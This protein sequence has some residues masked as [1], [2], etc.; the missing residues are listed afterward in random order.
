MWLSLRMILTN[1]RTMCLEVRM[2][3]SKV[4]MWVMASPAR[5]EVDLDFS[6]AAAA[7]VSDAVVMDAA[8]VGT[9]TELDLLLQVGS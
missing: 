2:G 9:G 7:V 5:S 8:V 4:Q 1:C 3:P 6:A